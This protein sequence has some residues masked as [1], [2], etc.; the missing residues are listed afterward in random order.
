MFDWIL[1][2]LLIIGGLYLLVA[3]SGFTIRGT[4]INFGWA[5]LVL[6]IILLLWTLYD[7]L[8]GKN[9]KKK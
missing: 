1:S 4:N 3:N 8:K 9:K 2:G 5:A 6:G 7:H